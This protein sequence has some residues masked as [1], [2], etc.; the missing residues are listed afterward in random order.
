MSPQSKVFQAFALEMSDDNQTPPALSARGEH[1]LAEH[2]VA[3]AKRHG[4][5]IVER[6]HVCTALENL[7][8]DEHIPMELFEVAAKILAEVGAVIQ[9]H[10]N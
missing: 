5:P 6:P 7:D 8:V 1:E 4:I 10:G 9:G 3:C 2:I